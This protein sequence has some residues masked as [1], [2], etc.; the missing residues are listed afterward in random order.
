MSTTNKISRLPL[1]KRSVFLVLRLITLPLTFEAV[2]YINDLLHILTM[3]AELNILFEEPITINATTIAIDNS[4][5]L[6]GNT[7]SESVFDAIE[8]RS[9][10]NVSV[11]FKKPHPNVLTVEYEGVSSFKVLLSR[12][13]THF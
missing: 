4:T 7:T 10:G 8:R 5:V 2:C 12:Y 3:L 9:Y 6:Y 11:T 1:F 13:L